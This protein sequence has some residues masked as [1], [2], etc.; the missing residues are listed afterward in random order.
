MFLTRG[1]SHN[2]LKTWKH[3]TTMSLDCPAQEDTSPVTMKP[4][5]FQFFT[6]FNIRPSLSLGTVGIIKFMSYLVF[7]CVSGDWWRSFQKHWRHNARAE[8]LNCCECQHNNKQQHFIIWIIISGFKT[9]RNVTQTI[10]RGEEGNIECVISITWMGILELM[11]CHLWTCLLVTL[12][13]SSACS[14]VGKLSYCCQCRAVLLES[15]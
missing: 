8:Q 2:I 9:A 4:S 12:P 11:L 15:V 13:P 3:N 10:T 6:S 14:L 7:L 5:Q 1:T